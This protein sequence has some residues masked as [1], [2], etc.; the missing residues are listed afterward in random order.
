MIGMRVLCDPITRGYEKIAGGKSN[1]VTFCGDFSANIVSACISMP[2]H[3]LWNYTVSTPEMW[4]KPMGE[5]V[6]MSL[7]YLRNQY[8]TTSASGST[9]ISSVIL[10]DAFLRSAYIATIYTTFVNLERAAVKYWPR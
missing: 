8:L 3:Q 2:I 1:T 5:R 10:R 4:D 6:K 9:T 7:S